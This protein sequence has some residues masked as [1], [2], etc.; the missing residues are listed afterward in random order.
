MCKLPFNY[1]GIEK[2]NYKTLLVLRKIVFELVK[3]KYSYQ[4]SKLY[5]RSIILYY[6]PVATIYIEKKY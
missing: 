5:V 1:L 4:I 2:M 3:L 6:V